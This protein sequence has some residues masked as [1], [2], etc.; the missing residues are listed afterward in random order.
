MSK[1]KIPSLMSETINA[2][3]RIKYEIIECSENNFIKIILPNGKIIHA[4]F[5]ITDSEHLGVTIFEDNSERFDDLY[6]HSI[7]TNL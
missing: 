4:D 3:E 2:Y 6:T 7:T 5:F 1:E